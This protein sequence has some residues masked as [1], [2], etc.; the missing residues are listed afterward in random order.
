[1]LLG[2]NTQQWLGLITALFST[3]QTIAVVVFPN[4]DPVALAIISG[5]VTGFLGVLIAFIAHT[6]TTPTHDPQLKAGTMVRVTDESGTVVGHTPVP[7][8]DPVPPA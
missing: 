6:S 1:M 8:P 2:R 4:V 3:V 5:S 7:Q